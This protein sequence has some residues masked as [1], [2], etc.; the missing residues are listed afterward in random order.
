MHIVLV[1][2]LRSSYF[3]YFCPKFK[4]WCRGDRG[5]TSSVPIARQWL[6]VATLIKV[7]DA[8]GAPQGATGIEMADVDPG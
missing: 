2:S 6:V 8:D 1:V 7:P 3:S 5:R 4:K